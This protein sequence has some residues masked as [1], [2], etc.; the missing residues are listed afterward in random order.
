MAEEQGVVGGPQEG[1]TGR[2]LEGR[3]RVRPAAG[4][5]HR[6]SVTT[7]AAAEDG[8]RRGGVI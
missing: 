5:G 2:Q 6:A 7:L 8:D 1:G 4:A 3:D